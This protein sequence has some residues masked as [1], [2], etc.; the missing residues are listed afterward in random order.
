MSAHSAAAAAAAPASGFLAHAVDP[1]EERDYRKADARVRQNP[2]LV[3]IQTGKGKATT[4]NLPP[5]GFTYG[6]RDHQLEEGVKEVV[7]SW[8]KHTPAPDAIP[9]RDFVRMNRSAVVKGAVSSKDIVA[10]R[11]TH[12]ARVKQGA[13]VTKGAPLRLDP[14]QTFGRPS[15]PSTPIHDVLN[16]TFQRNAII[17]AQRAQAEAEAR[18]N[19]AEGSKAGKFGS[20]Q[21]TRASLGHMKIRAPPAREPFKLEK[22]RQVGPR[23]GH[24]GLATLA[25]NADNQQRQIRAQQQGYDQFVNEPQQHDDQQ[26]QQQGSPQQQ[27]T[28]GSS[29]RFEEE[30]TQEGLRY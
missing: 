27:Q 10:F 6:R 4:Y 7:N 17:E 30:K 1:Y 24:Q 11:S 21:H 23:I 22:F 26:Q 28:G 13:T 16:N 19:K 9:G 20:S 14:Q 12:D 18:R 29:E 25:A 15:K 2:L 3:K 8:Q 5:E